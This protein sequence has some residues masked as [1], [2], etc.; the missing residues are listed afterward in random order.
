MMNDQIKRK[1]TEF[2]L[3][4]FQVICC[5]STCKQAEEKIKTSDSVST[6][7]SPVSESG[8]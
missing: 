4:K 3:N 6:V 2:F 8:N 5:K 7:A 1:P